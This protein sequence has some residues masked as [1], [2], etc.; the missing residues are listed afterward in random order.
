[1]FD[2]FLG[3]SEVKE[4]KKISLFSGYSETLSLNSS[5]DFFFNNQN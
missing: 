5:Y 2:K 1:M 4:G 3:I